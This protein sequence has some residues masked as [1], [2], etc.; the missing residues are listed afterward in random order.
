MLRIT[1]SKSQQWSFDLKARL[2]KL[3]LC[4]WPGI[5]LGNSG[6]IRILGYDPCFPYKEFTQDLQKFLYMP[7]W[8]LAGIDSFCH[9]QSQQTEAVTFFRESFCRLI[10]TMEIQTSDLKLLVENKLSQLMGWKWLSKIL[11]FIL[12]P[13]GI[14]TFGQM[15]QKD[16]GQK[17]CIG[18]CRILM[19]SVRRQF[20]AWDIPQTV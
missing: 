17:E 7:I 6:F 5:V 19:I 18:L 8:D 11:L 9:F 12:K 15:L 2:A 14:G 10:W 16:L 4:S 20:A 3:F 1:G 13:G